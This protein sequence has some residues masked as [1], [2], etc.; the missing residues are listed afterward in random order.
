MVVDGFTYE[1]SEPRRVD[2]WVGEKLTVAK[3]S[4]S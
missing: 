4:I 1:S 3:K 2:R